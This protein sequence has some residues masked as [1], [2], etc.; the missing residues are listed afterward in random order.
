[1]D[2]APYKDGPDARSL[3]SDDPD[4]MISRLVDAGRDSTKSTGSVCLTSEEISAICSASQELLLSQP[5]L[6]EVSAPVKIVG[7]IHG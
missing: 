3:K 5:S 6:L 4:D 1:M 2:Q 7:D